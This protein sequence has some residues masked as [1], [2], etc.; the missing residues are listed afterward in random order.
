[1]KIVNEVETRIHDTEHEVCIESTGQRNTPNDTRRHRT[2]PARPE[3]G[4]T[5]DR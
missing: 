2:R 5:E 3:N 1:M 4:S